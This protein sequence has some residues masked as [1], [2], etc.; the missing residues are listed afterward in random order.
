[1]TVLFSRVGLNAP[2]VARLDQHLAGVRPFAH[3]NVEA[4]NIA[5]RQVKFG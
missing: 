2:P 3:E 1:M 5:K 4:V